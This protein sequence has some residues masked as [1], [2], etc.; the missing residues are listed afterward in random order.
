M[1]AESMSK[2]I[3]VAMDSSGCALFISVAIGL[4]QTV[5]ADIS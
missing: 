4:H 3:T 2:H 5:G 1:K